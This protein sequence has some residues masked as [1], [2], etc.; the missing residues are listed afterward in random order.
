MPKIHLVC[1][2]A[3]KQ[4][5]AKITE[6]HPDIYITV[7]M[8]DDILTENGIVLPGLGDSGDRLYATEPVDDD[9]ES[10]LLP[11]KRKRTD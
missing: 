4:G 5:L 2:L 3:S 8:V 11:S 9:D 6:E 7:G 1:V 10:L